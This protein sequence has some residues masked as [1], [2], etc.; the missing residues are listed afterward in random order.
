MKP[1]FVS[2]I[3]CLVL[4]GCLVGCSS[5]AEGPSVERSGPQPKADLEAGKNAK[6][7]SDWAKANPN[8]G[9][10]GHGD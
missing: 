5:E 9:A 4:G 8:N 6:T 1:G 2:A 3:V 7:I 10:A